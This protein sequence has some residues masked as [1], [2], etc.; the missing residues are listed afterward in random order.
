MSFGISAGTAALIGGGLAAGASVYGAN[1]QAD[2]ARAATSAQQGMSEQTRADQAPWRAAGQVALG[3]IGQMSAPGG[4][5]L[6]E[7][8]A[9][10]LKSNLS[11]NYQFQLQ[12]GLGAV[13]NSAA[14]KGGLV[15]GNALKAINDY[16]QNFAG[17]AY[18]NA[19]NN[20]TANQT[21]IYNRLA[22][23][24]GL[25]QQAGMNS[26]TG[27]S[28]FSRGISDTTVG[29]GTAIGSGI[30]GAGNAINK[31]LNNSFAWNAYSDNNSSNVGGY[32]W[33]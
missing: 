20:Y 5:F 24:S 32:G 22:G 19:F 6:H 31:G 2:A 30:I 14:A 15:G 21:N 10:D 4:Q 12:Q 26:S 17:N 27:A 3:Q 8:N 13:Q 29:Q 9:D 23:I 33:I 25:G 1:Q 16:A 18:Q 28:D 7:F 11:P